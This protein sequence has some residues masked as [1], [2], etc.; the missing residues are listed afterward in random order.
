LRERSLCHDSGILHSQF[1]ISGK[2]KRTLTRP[3]L[4]A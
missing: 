3:F 2:I 1:P 4:F